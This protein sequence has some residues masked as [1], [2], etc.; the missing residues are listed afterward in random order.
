MKRLSLIAAIVAV[1]AVWPAASGAATFKGI[2]V[3][4]QHGALLVASPSGSVTSVSGRASIGSRVSV[5][6]GRA[7]VVGRA[8]SAR[9]RGVVVKRVGSTLFV[10][11]NRHLVA[12]H[13]GR[14]LASANDTAPIPTTPAPTTPAPATPA[15]GTIVS[16]QVAIQGNGELDQESSED[17]GQSS[18]N[19]LQVQAVV[20][21]VGVGTVTL[22][23]GT[24]TLTVPLPVGLTLPAAMVGQTVTLSIDLNGQNGQGGDDSSGNGGGDNGGGGDD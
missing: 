2:V 15:P 19:T 17:V 20:A 16:S 1:A 6:G 22:T 13:T 7:S 4:K 10:S 12:L 21:S 23:V 24:Q 5:S 8:H 11:S 14:V 9:I 3:A 18:S